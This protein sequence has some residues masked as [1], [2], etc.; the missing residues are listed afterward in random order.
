LSNF[1]DQG[2]NQVVE[3]LLIEGGVSVT[4]LEYLSPKVVPLWERVDCLLIRVCILVGGVIG[5][6]V[7]DVLMENLLGGI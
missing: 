7:G 2:V 3:A 6:V 4:P 1:I 5:V